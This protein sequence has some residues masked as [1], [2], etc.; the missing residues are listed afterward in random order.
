MIPLELVKIILQ[1]KREFK[2]AFLRELR[3]EIASR[4]TLCWMR[5]VCCEMDYYGKYWVCIT[6][7]QY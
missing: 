4:P 6:E 2:Q 5:V 7:N 1:Y 3:T